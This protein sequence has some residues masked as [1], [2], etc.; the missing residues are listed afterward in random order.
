MASSSRWAVVQQQQ[1]DTQTRM[2]GNDGSPVHV[3]N[4]Y[5]P[6]AEFKVPGRD[7][8]PRRE[9]KHGSARGAQSPR[10]RDFDV[11]S[12]PPPDGETAARWTQAV[13]RPR[14]WARRPVLGTV[15]PAP[16][17]SCRS[18]GRVLRPGARDRWARRAA[19]L[20]RGA[21][22]RR[23]RS[24]RAR[25]RLRRDDVAPRSGHRTR[26]RGDE[27]LRSAPPV[28]EPADAHSAPP[29][30]CEDGGGGVGSGGQRPNAPT[31]RG[32]R[33]EQASAQPARRGRRTAVSATA[34]ARRLRGNGR[35]VGSSRP[36][37][38]PA[39]DVEPL[40]EGGHPGGAPPRWRVV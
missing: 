20:P 23:P 11:G 18:R 6:S 39:S 8:S 13:T 25:W 14:W 38:P 17:T 19:V 37:G 29:V 21:P 16:R 27:G 10:P 2:C 31:A 7:L 26:G 24:P 32:G 35:V 12:S 36:R 40:F 5:P 1:A 33:S 28:G 22:P 15:G 9:A 34:S 30:Q 4:R 3:F